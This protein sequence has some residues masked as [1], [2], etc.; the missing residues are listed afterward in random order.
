MPPVPTRV[1]RE[2]YLTCA[3]N[4]LVI[5]TAPRS[6]TS[7]SAAHVTCKLDAQSGPPGW[8][9]AEAGQLAAEQGALAGHRLPHL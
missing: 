9:Q 8:V 4:D 2:I 7:R 1:T 3:Q 5:T 6:C